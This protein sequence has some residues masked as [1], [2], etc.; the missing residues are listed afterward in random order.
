MSGIKTTKI[1]NK[2]INIMSQ[3]TFNIIAF[4]AADKTYYPSSMERAS[5]MPENW[6]PVDEIEIPVGSSRYGGPVMDLPPSIT[7]PADLN[8][9]GQI[10]LSKFWPS[11][12]SGL[13]P[14]KGHL[15]FFADILA[16]TG[17]VIFTECE[18]DSLVRTVREHED[19]FFS[20]TLI[21]KIFPSSENWDDRFSIDEEEE[22]EEDEDGEED[23]EDN[24]K[25]SWNYF[26][27]SDQ[28]KIFGIFTHCQFSQQEI[29]E[30]ASSDELV[31]FQVG[32]NGFNDEGVF[33]VTIKK[34]DLINRNFDN[35][36]FYWG[37]S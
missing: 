18:T 14:E 8:Y 24:G 32:E 4:T 1:S 5:W 31:L 12:A 9:A 35:C 33:T 7:P 28:S 2:I 3:K 37:Q 6:V 34:D 30:I 21:D 16:D 22:D 20:G 15:I 17:R 19:N 26:A 36:Q 11:D 29:E 27:G 10:D 13:L 23:K 25:P